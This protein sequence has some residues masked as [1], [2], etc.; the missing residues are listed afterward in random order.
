M[1]IETSYILYTI[2]LVDRSARR[3]IFTR[4]YFQKKKNQKSVIHTHTHTH[5]HTH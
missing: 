1:F 4:D 3:R 2:K 5:T